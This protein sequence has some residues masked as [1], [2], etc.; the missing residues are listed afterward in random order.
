MMNEIQMIQ[1][2]A[3][4][5]R[6]EAAP[7]VDVADRVVATIRGTCVRPH[8]VLWGAAAVSALAAAFIGVVAMG[9]G[10]AFADPLQDM[11]TPFLTVIQ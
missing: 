1:R 2:L 5:A 9:I 3:G 6:Q 10:F 11:F 8:I 4:R 7:P